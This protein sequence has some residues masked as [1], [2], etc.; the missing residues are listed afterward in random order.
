MIIDELL[1]GGLI[2]AIKRVEC[3]SEVALEIAARLG[4]LVHD[5]VALL[6]G[7]AGSER[8]IGQVSADS[9]TSGFDHGGALFVE[10]RAIQGRS[11]HIGDVGVRRAMLVVVHNDL[12]EEVGERGVGVGGA[13]V[14]TD[15]RVGVLAARE[16]ASLE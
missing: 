14:A 7:D 3:A 13:S 16:D 12:I 4:N 15:A 10:R 11:V 2:H 5:F 8:H 6:V 1:L 9:D